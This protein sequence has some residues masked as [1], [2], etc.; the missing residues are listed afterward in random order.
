MKPGP[1][2]FLAWALLAGA[3]PPAAHAADVWADLLSQEG[4]DGDFEADADLDQ[5]PD[6]WLQY[7]EAA[8]GF[9]HYGLVS[10]VDRPGAGRRVLLVTNGTNVAIQTRQA[11]PIDPSFSYLLE[12]E[13]ALAHVAE[14]GGEARVALE[15]LD[16]AGRRISVETLHRERRAG[17]RAFAVEIHDIPRAAR[18][19]RVRLEIVQTPVV[20]QGPSLE[21]RVAYDRIKFFRRPR[22]EFDV[23][24]ASGLFRRGGEPPVF[25]VRYW[26]LPAG[27]YRVEQE[28]RDFRGEIL[29]RDAVQ[30]EPVVGAIE[31]TWRPPDLP[32]GWFFWTARF[33][34]EGT[35]LV[36]RRASVAVLPPSAGNHAGFGLD[37]G[38]LEKGRRGDRI[39]LLKPGFVKVFLTP[40]DDESSPAVSFLKWMKLLQA[41]T[42]AVLRAPPETLS[43]LGWLESLSPEADTV[44]SRAFRWVDG[45]ILEDPPTADPH[46]ARWAAARARVARLLPLQ[47]TPVRVG[48]RRA[49]GGRRGALDPLPPGVDLWDLP[50]A[51]AAGDARLDEGPSRIV[52][53]RGGW[54]D[55]RRPGDV[56]GAVSAFVREAVSLKHRGAEWLSLPADDPG[57][58]WGAD[59]WPTPFLAAWHHLQ[60]RLGGARPWREAQPI[61]PPDVQGRV[62]E[63]GG[64]LVIAAWAE[65]EATWQINLGE[66]VTVEDAMGNALPVEA[67]AGGSLFRLGPV[68]RYI[69]GVDPEVVQTLLTI[70]LAPDAVPAQEAAFPVALSFTS[71][72]AEPVHG[73]LRVEMGAGWRVGS[74]ERFFSLKPGESW[75]GRFLVT[76]GADLETEGALH[77]M[78][79]TVVLHGG[80]REQ[81]LRWSHGVTLAS[82]EIACRVS[83][84]RG[85]GRL[86]SLFHEVASRS[87]DPLVLES[88][89]SLPGRADQV[90]PLGLVAPG[91][92]AHAVH[93]FPAD[94]S[95][96][97]AT[98][99][100]REVRGGRR[101]W[102]A[103]VASAAGLAH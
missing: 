23:G 35:D 92:K 103:P 8:E 21:G 38:R 100:V 73:R 37:C 24:S 15:W 11:V 18:G 34:Q 60:L 50:A 62:F 76:P 96:D 63:Q 77:A 13:M 33:G 14:R 45:W 56:S 91:A 65:R 74:P 95:L 27:R 41:E 64:T 86:A 57:G 12:G 99:A 93:R 53:I 47:T 85:E 59:G 7:Q 40:E 4:Q 68:P 39:A 97:G 75:S 78:T 6:R 22:S 69:R 5:K 29:A 25:T 71:A 49:S 10:L 26:G 82:G 3:F 81:I 17:E 30:T 83:L 84:A 67:R 20:G 61:L 48:A 90:I 80:G 70:R 44:F 42:F 94:L 9:M 98:L 66:N 46:D 1:R 52:E 31:R 58:A 102:R 79:V 51:A 19:A 87:A 89:L 2:F 55:P 88:V 101:F 43:V 16:E 72:F 36:E 54:I 28:V 32:C